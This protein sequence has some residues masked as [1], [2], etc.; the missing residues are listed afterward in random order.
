MKINMNTNTVT[1]TFTLPTNTL[2]VGHFAI[3]GSNVYYTID[4]DIYKFSSTAHALPLSPAFTSDAVFLYGFA[5]KNNKIYVGDAKFFNTNGV[6][7]VYSS[8]ESFDPN[9]IGTLLTPIPI[10]VGVGPNG[11]YFNQ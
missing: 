6:V 7:Y 2:H 10:E 9:V 4:S 3:F 1:E 11:F 8:G 5:V